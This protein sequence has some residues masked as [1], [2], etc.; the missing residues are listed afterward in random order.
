MPSEEF[1]IKKR[2]KV[3]KETLTPLSN[4]SATNLVQKKYSKSGVD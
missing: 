3:T 4:T 2:R 1:K